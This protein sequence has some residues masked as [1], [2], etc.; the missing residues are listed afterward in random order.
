ME[1]TRPLSALLPQSR[2][3]LPLPVQRHDPSQPSQ[4]QPATTTVLAD[5]DNVRRWQ[6]EQQQEQEHGQQQQQQQ[7][8]EAESA[9]LRD[10]SDGQQRQAAT[11]ATGADANNGWQQQQLLVPLPPLLMPAGT[12]SDTRRPEYERI[13]YGNEHVDVPVAILASPD[14]PRL[15]LH[16]VG[17]LLRAAVGDAAGGLVLSDAERS[18]VLVRGARSALAPSLGEAFVRRRS[19][20]RPRTCLTR[21]S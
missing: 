1:E 17:D 11:V 9:L 20:Q 10:G 5:D 16:A 7:Q 18:A 6:V 13:L 8:P 15:M 21:F 4:Q 19:V 12:A 3:L 14:G 2:Q